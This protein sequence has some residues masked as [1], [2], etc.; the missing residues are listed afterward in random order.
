MYSNQT[1]LTSEGKSIFYQ[2][3]WTD[4][5]FQTHGKNNT[6]LNTNKMYNHLKF[7]LSWWKSVQFLSC[8]LN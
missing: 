7:E 4:D 5:E 1:M 6:I 8:P 3:V 2:F